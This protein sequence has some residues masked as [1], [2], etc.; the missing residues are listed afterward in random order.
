MRP[1]RWLSTVFPTQDLKSLIRFRQVSGAILGALTAPPKHV[2]I[3]KARIGEVDGEWIFA[4]GARDEPVLVFIHG[5]GMFF[6]LNNLFR[7]VLGNLS[8]LS[9]TRVFAVDYD[10]PPDHV[11]P[12]AHDQ[13]YASYRALAEQGK[14]VV[15]I[16]ESSGGALAL[17]TLLRAAKAGLPQPA[18]CVLISPVLDFGFRDLKGWDYE[19]I[20]ADPGFAIGLHQHYVAGCD[21][22][23]PD[24]RPVDADLTGLAPIYALAGERDFTR[25]DVER[26]DEGLQRH[27]AT[28]DYMLWPRAWHG[29]T[30]FGSVLPE[31]RDAQELL[32][33]VIRKHVDKVD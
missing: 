33:E 3:V 5:G 21:L 27:G 13:C 9:E 14:R 8:A 7:K 10:L 2:R 1:L 25:R 31:A 19:A 18:L 24:L 15:L 6:P 20:F 28:L 12:T 16:G 11:Y 22:E 23:N 29:W 17:A 32:G 4:E 26:L 30:L